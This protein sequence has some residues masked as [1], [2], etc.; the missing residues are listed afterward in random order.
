MFV[1]ARDV[2]DLVVAIHRD[3]LDFNEGDLLH[4]IWRFRRYE[5]KRLPIAHLNLGEWRLDKA[6]VA[7]FLAMDPS[8]MPPIVFDPLD[9]SI[10]DGAHRANA[11]AQR[12][13]SDIAAY[14]GSPEQ[15][16]PDWTR[17]PDD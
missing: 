9:R 7:D 6:R 4:R 17:D 3:E 2:Q 5:L 14:V 11:C 1:N 13:H 12:G 8:T 10:I 16:D 15:V